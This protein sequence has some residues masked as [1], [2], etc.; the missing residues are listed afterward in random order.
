MLCSVPLSTLPHAPLPAN[1]VRAQ[2]IQNSALSRR[3]GHLFRKL[4][5]NVGEHDLDPAVL[6]PP[7]SCRIAG[8]RQGAAAPDR[9]DTRGIDAI[10]L[11]GSS[12]CHGTAL[13]ERIIQ[14]I[15][16]TAIGEAFNLNP[17]LGM[18]LQKLRD[19]LQGGKGAGLDLVTAG[20]KQDL[21][22][23]D[24]DRSAFG[25]TRLQSSE[26]L[27]GL[28]LLELSL[29]GL[30]LG[31]GGLLLGL[32][33]GLDDLLPGLLLGLLSGPLGLL[34]LL[35]GELSPLLS[36]GDLLLGLSVLL[37]LFE[38]RKLLF[39]LLRALLGL[40]RPRF[41][42]LRA[43]TLGL[44]HDPIAL[45]LGLSDLSASAHLRGHRLP[46]LSFARRK[47]R[48][49]NG[50]VGQVMAGRLIGV[51]QIGARFRERSGGGLTRERI[52]LE[53]LN[54][55][56]RLLIGGSLLRRRRRACGQERGGRSRP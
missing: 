19:L 40:T 16:A 55:I 31:L 29:L 51:G 34:R 22:A 33:A 1:T 32:L 28:L 15:R 2:L 43:V 27:A 30:L 24:D 42:Y 38:L 36:R 48:P 10:R 54:L 8:E 3:L 35:L 4:A 26:L 21:I 50:L 56:A 45:L 11:Q 49:M 6:L 53:P 52:G 46:D 44:L 12:D 37:L 18:I 7:G 5:V 13:R 39:G 23:Q 25:L 17:L 20:G 14:N 41:R 9:L 47:I